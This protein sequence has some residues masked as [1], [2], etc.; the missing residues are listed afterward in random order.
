ME[1]FSP[2]E[3]GASY[4]TDVGSNPTVNKNAKKGSTAG[5]SPIDAPQKILKI[6]C[7]ISEVIPIHSTGNILS[8][9]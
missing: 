2:A 3:Q 7:S 6:C 9:G 8:I 1:S 4:A 5:H